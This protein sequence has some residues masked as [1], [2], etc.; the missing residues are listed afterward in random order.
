MTID[1][2][3]KKSV[4]HLDR[5]AIL[6]IVEELKKLI[7]TVEVVQINKNTI[8]E[9][10]HLAVNR[11]QGIDMIMRET[12]RD[13]EVEVIQALVDVFLIVDVHKA[14]KVEIIQEEGVIV[15]TEKQIDTVNKIEEEIIPMIETKGE[16][17][18]PT[19]IGI[20]KGTEIG[21]ETENIRIETM[22]EIMIMTGRGDRV[23]IEIGTLE[24]RVKNGIEGESKVMIGIVGLMITMEEENK[25]EY[26]YIFTKGI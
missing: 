17:V 8:N 18:I 10:D 4:L 5:G 22:I 15:E 16:I 14:A 6:M 1:I 3:T 9:K 23:I 21:I 12:I 24:V 2:E 11:N 25:I 7:I 19:G 26:K 13:I 20:E